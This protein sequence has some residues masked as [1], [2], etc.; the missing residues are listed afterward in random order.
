[1]A[2]GEEKAIF[3]GLKNDAQQA[4]PK[5]AE[6]AST[7]A[8]DTA[9]GAEKALDAHAANE[10]QVTSDL[11]RLAE[12]PLE[13]LPHPASSAAPVSTPPGQATSILNSLSSEDSAAAEIKPNATKQLEA[14]RASKSVSQVR[15]IRDVRQRW[16][17]AEEN[18]R[19]RYGGGPE[20]AYPVP[21]NRDPDFPIDE[22]TTRKVDCPVDLPDGG[23]LAV[24]VKMYQQYRNIEVAPGQFT[25]QKVEVPLS[26]HIKLQINKDVALRNADNGFD[27]RWEFQGAGPSQELR[28]YLTKARI[29]FIEHK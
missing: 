5:A 2:D 1:M 20:R 19:Q 3:V 4:L 7:F 18:A 8:D 9:T 6:Q 25:P 16:Q 13:G 28:D 15:S 26:D 29:I 12:T 22:P 17:N 23:T 11:N 14:G 10:A 24:E 21:A 27:P